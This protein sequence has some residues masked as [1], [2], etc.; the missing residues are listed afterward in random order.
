MTSIYF[1]EDHDKLRA[2]IRKFVEAELIPNEMKWEEE[3]IFPR[4]LFTKMGELGF[5]GIKFPEEYGGLGLDY[6][7]NVVFLEELSRTSGGAALSIFAHTDISATLVNLLGNH[8]QK[9]KYLSASITGEMIGALGVTEANHGSDVAGIET[10]AIKD[11]S[12]YVVNGSKMYIT[13]GTRADYVVLAA[14]TSPEHGYKGI[15]LFIMD[16]DLPGYRISKKLDK[17]GNRASDT[18][19]LSFEDVRIPAENLLG[20]ENKGFYNIMYNFQG[21]RLA[22]AIAGYA[23]AEKVWELTMK[24]CNERKAFGQPISKFQVNSHKLVDMLTEIEAG[25]QL[26]YHAAWLYDQGKECTREVSIAKLF[27]T[28]MCFRVLNQAFQ[29]Y[30]GAGYMMEYPVQRFWRDARLTTIGAGTS[31]IMKEIISKRIGL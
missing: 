9:Q 25:K 29:L 23:S 30:G 21:E 12:H 14:K 3:G 5:L 26:T 18:A 10:K 13:N 28:E 15:S 8:Q 16:T 31:E 24:Y 6:F 11:G 20:E 22:A 2:S 17:V 19:E 27:N 4:E 7:S 1:N